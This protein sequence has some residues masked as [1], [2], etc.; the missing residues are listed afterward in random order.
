MNINYHST[1]NLPYG[2]TSGGV[3]FDDNRKVLLLFKIEGGS[4]TYHL[5][6]GTLKD[7]S[8]EAC[9]SEKLWKLALE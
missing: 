9:A 3:V 4:K 5:P 8:L 1:R 7:E 2:I 6:K